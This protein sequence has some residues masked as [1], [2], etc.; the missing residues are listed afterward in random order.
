MTVERIV[1]ILTHSEKRVLLGRERI[2]GCESSL[3]PFVYSPR[4]TEILWFCRFA[5]VGL[6]KPPCGY[7]FQGE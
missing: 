5:P 1:S 2:F 6:I 7:S 4:W 3:M